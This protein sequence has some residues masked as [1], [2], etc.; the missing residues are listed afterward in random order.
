M[1]TKFKTITAQEGSNDSIV[2][3]MNISK[4]KKASIKYNSLYDKMLI[5]VN[6]SKRIVC[7]S[8]KLLHIIGKKINKISVFDVDVSIFHLRF[9]IDNNK[10]NKKIN[11]FVSN[12][13]NDVIDE[14]TPIQNNY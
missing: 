9:F 14:T 12:I 7:K 1:R 5:K 8:K 6:N 10:I 4:K 2:S 13:F 11:V 3:S